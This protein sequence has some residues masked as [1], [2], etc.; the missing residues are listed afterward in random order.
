M[1]DDAV[2][3]AGERQA[4]QINVAVSFQGGQKQT[5]AAEKTGPKFPVK[6]N[7]IFCAKGCAQERIFLADLVPA[8][9]GHVNGNNFSG[10]GGGKSHSFF[11]MCQINRATVKLNAT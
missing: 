8:D 11:V 6:G 2:C 10:I 5:F 9:G 1:A 7:G 3:Q 4:L